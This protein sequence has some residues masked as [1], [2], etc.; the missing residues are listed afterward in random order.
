[1]KKTNFM[2]RLFSLMLV[3]VIVAAMTA[4]FASCGNKGNSNDIA[5][6]SSTAADIQSDG[7][8]ADT[9]VKDTEEA[10]KVTIIVT[11]KSADGTS[12]DF[13]ITTDEEFLRGALEQEN[14]IEGE[15][16]E[17][18]L[19]VKVVCGETADYDKDGAYWAF[20]KDGEYL[21]TGVD[22]TPIAD[23]DSFSIEYTVG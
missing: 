2:T 1:M 14:L 15:E 5:D 11:V 18:G 8:S 16:S 6:S 9:D 23:G 7:T 4:A 22:T 19:Y 21:M 12:K 3:L 20:Y 13:S 10:Q 17:Y